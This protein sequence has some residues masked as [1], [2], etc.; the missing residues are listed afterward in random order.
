MLPTVLH[1]MAGSPAVTRQLTV[2]DV[3]ADAWYAEAVV[4]ARENKVVNGISDTEFAPDRAITR[5]ELVT[6]LYRYAAAVWQG[7][8]QPRSTGRLCG[9][10]FCL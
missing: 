6:M 10:R 9:R 4:W 1:R 8:F 3:A 7:H 2:C 5:E